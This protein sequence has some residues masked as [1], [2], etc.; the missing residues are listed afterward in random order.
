[1]ENDA[2]T[3]AVLIPTLILA[4]QYLLPGRH[5]QPIEIAGPLLHPAAVFGRV[6]DM[7]LHPEVRS[8]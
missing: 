6:A 1:M 4:R 3:V 7:N 8:L 5:R 2:R